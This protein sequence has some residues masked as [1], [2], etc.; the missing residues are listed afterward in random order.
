[1][2]PGYDKTHTGSILDLGAVM[3]VSKG[4]K[5]V[6]TL[7]PSAGYYSSTDPSLGSVGMVGSKPP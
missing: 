5:H 7:Y 3:D 1:M 2:L 4:A 6:T